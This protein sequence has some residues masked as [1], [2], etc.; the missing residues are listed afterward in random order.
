MRVAPEHE[1]VLYFRGLSARPAL[2]SLPS[3]AHARTVVIRAPRRLLS[4]AEDRFAWPPLEWWTGAVQIVH[5]THFAL[6]ASRRARRVLTVHDL[7]YL[8][9]PEFYADKKLNEYGYCRLLP[10]S[11]ARADA[12][13]AISHATAE[14]LEE[15]CDVDP[16][17]IWVVPSGVD[18]VF[19][20]V[21]RRDAAPLLER[22]GLD[23]PFALYPCG[24]I[25]PR[26]NMERVLRAFAQAFPA[27]DTRPLLVLTGVGEFPEALT[28]LANSLGIRA[29]VR[30]HRVDY[31]H[32]LM[33]LLSSAAWGM[34]LSR[35][36]G[37]GLPV[38]EAM[39]CGMP[40]LASN[41]S[42]IPEVAGDAALLVD[43]CD[44][45]AIAAG[46]RRLGEDGGL[47]DSLAARGSARAA[48]ATFSWDR[49]ARQ[50]LAVYRDD[51]AAYDAEPCTCAPHNAG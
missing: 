36:E 17:R 13:I 48:S 3:N 9:H 41:V 47:R 22:L 35:Y 50:M 43:P 23:R 5:G 27:P 15:L 28:C 37:F 20:P 34:Y 11:L 4:F 49:A 32:E 45:D 21:A 44:A 7:A 12:V 14:D 42:S 39:A 2:P 6:P 18:P 10:R 30:C 1:Y 40:L 46:M 33:A 19:K 26:K 31:P 8:R 25:E 51:R 38:L 29:Q 16:G 24:T